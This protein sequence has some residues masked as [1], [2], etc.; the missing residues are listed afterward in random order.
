MIHQELLNVID[1][2]LNPTVQMSGDDKIKNS[3][4]GFLKAL[5]AV[6]E[7]HQPHGK[8]MC[9]NCESTYYPC[10]TIQAVKNE[11]R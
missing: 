7:L 3:A 6:V 2:Y 9:I 5:R 11:L 8:V 10:S 1:Y 4:I